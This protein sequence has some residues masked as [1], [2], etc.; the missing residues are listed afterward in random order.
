MALTSAKAVVEELLSHFNDDYGRIVFAE[1]LKRGE[2]PEDRSQGGRQSLQ[3][4]LAAVTELHACGFITY[5]QWSDPSWFARHPSLKK[6]YEEDRGDVPASLLASG[7]DCC[8]DVQSSEMAKL[9]PA[10]D[11]IDAIFNW[12]HPA[13][14]G[15]LDS[16]FPPQRKSM[17]TTTKKAP[18]T[19]SKKTTATTKKT[20]TKNRTQ[21][22]KKPITKKANPKK[23]TP[24][25]TTQ[26]KK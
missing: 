12:L 15:F 25:K 9:H 17:A 6:V 16:D 4:L 23:T 22:A 13:T 1:K 21:T 7:G 11:E 19:N 26:T 18:E 8:G 5:R 10:L 3:R 20:I 14:A 2:Y 24:K